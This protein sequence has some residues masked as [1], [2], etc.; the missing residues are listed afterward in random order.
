MDNNKTVIFQDFARKAKQR[1]EEKKKKRT[2]R[3][4]VGDLGMEITVRGISDEEYTDI[5]EMDISEINRDKYL[6][7]YACEELQGA[8]GVMVEEGNLLDGERYKIAGMFSAVDRSRICNEILKLSG[9]KGD[10]TVKDA[11]DMP[12]RISE[13]DEVKN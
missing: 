4:Y 10:S 3:L 1:L 8:A 11:E 7:Y 13:L 5:V 2:K 12:E 9:L 6:I